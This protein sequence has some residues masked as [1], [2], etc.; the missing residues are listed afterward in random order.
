MANDN[1]TSNPTHSTSLDSAT[2][3]TE[4]SDGSSSS[5]TQLP[6][7]SSNSDKRLFDRWRT[8]FSV[9]TGVG[10][11]EGERADAL[12]ERHREV[13]MKWK[14]ELANYSELFF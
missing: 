4:S 14:T 12:A 7:F 2:S 8:A 10:M 13:C 1:Q 11:S 9:I 6:R 3:F 5:N